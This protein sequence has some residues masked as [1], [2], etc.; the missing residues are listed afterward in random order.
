VRVRVNYGDGTEEEEL[1]VT[2]GSVHFH[3]Y[4]DGEKHEVTVEVLEEDEI[5]DDA[6]DADEEDDDEYDEADV[7]DPAEYT[8]AEVVDYAITNPEQIDDLIAAEEAGKNRST[9]IA[10]LEA[11]QPVE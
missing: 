5:E 1:E 11:M 7:F 8:V 6:D 3:P 10:Q 2:D 4:E 9:L